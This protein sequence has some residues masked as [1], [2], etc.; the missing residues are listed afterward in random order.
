MLIQITA[1][2]VQ[3]TI[4]C[5]T[6]YGGSNILLQSTALFALITNYVKTLLQITGGITNWYD[7]R[8][9]TDSAFPCNYNAK[10]F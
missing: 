4:K 8:C 7:L 3:I 5:I 1:G 10:I 6:N 2:L 9:T